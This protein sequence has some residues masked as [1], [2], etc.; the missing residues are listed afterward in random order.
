MRSNFFIV[1]ISVFFSPHQD[2]SLTESQLENKLDSMSP[3]GAASSPPPQGKHTQ[4]KQKIHI[5]DS[6]TDQSTGSTLTYTDLQL[7]ISQQHLQHCIP[8]LGPRGEPVP[9][10]HNE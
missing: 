4:F 3:P 8:S 6:N 10:S 5:K 2:V 1:V 7:S 9:S